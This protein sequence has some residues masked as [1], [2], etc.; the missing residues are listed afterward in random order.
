VNCL[1]QNPKRRRFEMR[2]E[3]TSP[4]VEEFDIAERTQLEGNPGSDGPDP[5]DL[6]DGEGG[7]TDPGGGAPS[8]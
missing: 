1:L 3:W 7:G 4:E 2:E 6:G 5:F 8:S